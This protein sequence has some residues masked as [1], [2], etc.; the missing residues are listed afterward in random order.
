VLASKIIEIQVIPRN[1][2]PLAETKIE[3]LVD[4][5]GIHFSKAPWAQVLTCLIARAEGNRGPVELQGVTYSRRRYPFYPPPARDLMLCPFKLVLISTI[6]IYL[7]KYVEESK[8]GA[9]AKEL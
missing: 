7:R 3:M 6:T 2:L 1:S 4:Q 9:H 8:A 5:A